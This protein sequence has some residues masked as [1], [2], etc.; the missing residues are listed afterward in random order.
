M[1]L[2][3]VCIRRPVFTWVLVSIPVV[4]GLVSYF[5]LGVDL[6]PKVDFPVVSVTATLPGA[7]AEEMETSVTRP[8]EEAINTVSGVDELRST[9]REGMTTIVAQFLLEKNGDVAAQEV[10]DKISGILKQLPEGI[11]PPLVDKFDLDASPIIT[12]GV[13]GRRDARE[14]T[15]IAKHQIQEQL[16]T[17][18]GVGAVFLSGGRTRA[19]N[20]IIDIN[21]LAAYD[22][23]VED[24][25]RAIVAQNQ[26]V[27]GGIVEQGSRELV[28][29]TLGRIPSTDRFN[30]LIVA[31][32]KGYP[33]RIKDI[34]RAEDS[35]E[36]PRG[37]TRLDGDTAVSLFVQ[38]QS[39]TNTIQISNAVQA[40]LAKI[41]RTLPPDIKTEIIQD[42]SRFVRRSIE[43]VNFHLLLAALLV[44]GTILLFI[45]DWRTTLIATLA[46]PT[47][48]IP[49]FAFMYYMG[50]TLNNITM[51]G[52]IL[53]IGIV[54]DDA[55]VVHENIFRHMEENGLDAR[56]AASLGTSEI[57]LAVLAT[58]LSLVVI[59]VPVAFMG[60]M[61]GR[62][63]RS[64]GL[65]VAFAIMMSLFVSFTLTP[66]LCAHFLK[67][68][69]SEEG[70]AHSK[71]GWI[72]RLIDWFYGKS[73]VWAIGHRTI[74]V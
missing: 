18:S 23:S 66:M 22:L 16:Q 65:T 19:V 33:V 32:R 56:S 21:R 35:I 2:S 25:R 48:I 45:R 47:S 30:E 59:F 8:L 12:I 43:E 3:D 40:R 34:G 51:L 14:I 46:I 49:T 29:R 55:V 42:Q 41:A 28:L 67:L 9:V 70:T 72:Y 5:E 44:S 1:T 27:P 50:F 11:E 54:I 7:S 73:L 37:L 38:K 39:G 57:A 71:S 24:V 36:Q 62:F 63:F 17:V 31:N 60:G 6:F 68:E 61:V 69:P 58:S 52:L 4:L 74:M 26:E 15:E 53:A 10:R 20:V 64:F 13:S